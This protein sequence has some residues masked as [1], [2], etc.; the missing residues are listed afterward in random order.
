MIVEW[1]ERKWLEEET[2]EGSWDSSERDEC[3]YEAAGKP[4]YS[5]Q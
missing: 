3:S 1:K 5:H 4:Q 2:A